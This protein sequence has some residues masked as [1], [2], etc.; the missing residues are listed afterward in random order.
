MSRSSTVITKSVRLAP[1][2]SEN[3]K[4]ISKTEGV[5]EAALM[6]RLILE[7]LARL[8]LEEAIQAYAN[9]EVD[10]SAAARH[11]GVSVYKML[12][13]LQ[14]RDVAPPVDR[15][16]FLDGL[17]TLAE[18]FGGSEAL[19]QTIAQMRQEESVVSDQ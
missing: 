6:R 18:T 5:S 14:R 2:E 19:F 17:E 7:G 12:T 11:A 13:E 9:G 4:R 1:E 10:L 15:E 8:R 16:K 3:L